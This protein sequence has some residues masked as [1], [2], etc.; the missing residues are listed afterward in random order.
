M[1][2]EARLRPADID[3]IRVGQPATLRFSNFNQHETPEIDG[4]VTRVSADAVEDHR[5]EEPYYIVRL[6]FERGQRL[7]SKVLMP[8]MP[9]EV[10]IRTDSRSLMTYLTKP[11]LDQIRHAFR[12]R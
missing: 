5:I 4:M 7:A 10:F 8:G 1:T 9:V 6:G 2:V 3:Q 11:M 12:E